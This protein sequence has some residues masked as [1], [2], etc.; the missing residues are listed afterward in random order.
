MSS[1]YA[2]DI[3]ALDISFRFYM[4]KWPFQ[5][6]ICSKL[7]K[8]LL[9]GGQHIGKSGNTWRFFEHLDLPEKIKFFTVLCGNTRNIFRYHTFFLDVILYEV[10]GV[11]TL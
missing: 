5:E 8:N 6:K 9:Q 1:N 2:S 3:Q 10:V 4:E 11:S 7:S